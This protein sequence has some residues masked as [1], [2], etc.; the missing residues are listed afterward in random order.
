MT[1]LLNHHHIWNLIYNARRNTK[2]CACHAEKLT[3]LVPITYETSFR[4]RGATGITIHSDQILRL[5][6]K[7]I[8]MLYRPHIWNLISSARRIRPWSENKNPNRNPPRNRGYFSSSPQA[9]SIRKKQHFAAN[10]TFKPWPNTAPTTKSAT[11]TSPNIAPATKSDT[12]TS[13]STAPAIKSDTWTSPNTAPTTKNDTWTSPNT[14]P[15]T[16]YNT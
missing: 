4:V 6:R 10:L 3:Y 9:F 16:K 8:R 1:G 12:W 5:P 14:A 11:W 15:A 2:C 7:M 13:P